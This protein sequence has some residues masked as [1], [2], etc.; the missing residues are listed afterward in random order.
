MHKGNLEESLKEERIQEKKWIKEK[1]KRTRV[2]NNDKEIT[3][4]GDKI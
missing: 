4:E 2:R 1:Q 3:K